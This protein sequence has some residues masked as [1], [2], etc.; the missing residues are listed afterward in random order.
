MVE[1]GRAPKE[2][3]PSLYKIVRFKNME[4]NSQIVPVMK[5]NSREVT[6]FVKLWRESEEHKRQMF[7]ACW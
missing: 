5:I 1:L 2:I 3:A 7:G 6:Q 4:N